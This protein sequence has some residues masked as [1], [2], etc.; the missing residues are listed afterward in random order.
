M[1][2]PM[3][4]TK[5]QLSYSFYEPNMS[6]HNI[7]T[8]IESSRCAKEQDILWK[9]DANNIPKVSNGCLKATQY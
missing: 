7:T 2:I 6:K 4:N 5:E 1:H 3:L 9:T 8:I